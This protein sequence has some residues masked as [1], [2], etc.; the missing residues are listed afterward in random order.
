MMAPKVENRGHVA[1]AGHGNAL[2]MNKKTPFML[3]RNM[4]AEF[5]S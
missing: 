3:H 1:G 4:K 5:R 2:I